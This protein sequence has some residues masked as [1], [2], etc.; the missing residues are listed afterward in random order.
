MMIH[1]PAN[2]LKGGSNTTFQQLYMMR[3]L[4]KRHAFHGHI[5]TGHGYLINLYSEADIATN[6]HTDI[7]Q[8]MTFNECVMRHN[9]LFA[10]FLVYGLPMSTTHIPVVR[11]TLMRGNAIFINTDDLHNLIH[12]FPLDLSQPRIH[13]QIKT[14]NDLSQFPHID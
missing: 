7:V 10:N 9:Q 12:A 11:T 13:L 14:H 8:H 1:F 3:Q 5:H 4:L 6:I 2:N